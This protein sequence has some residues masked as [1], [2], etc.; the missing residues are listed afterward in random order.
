GLFQ[1][2][3][4]FNFVYRA[5]SHLTSGIVAVLFGLLML[6]NAALAR[7]FLGQAITRRF[8]LGSAIGLGGIALLLVNEARHAPAGGA[9]ALGVELALGG[10]LLASDANVMQATVRA[11]RQSL[12]V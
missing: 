2:C 10:L 1:F 7:I 3:L 11:R 9:V 12:L 8:L 4:N 5:E 6:P